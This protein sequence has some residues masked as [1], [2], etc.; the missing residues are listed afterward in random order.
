M[1]DARELIDEK[2]LQVEAERPSDER[3][4]RVAELPAETANGPLAVGADHNGT[5]HLLIPVTSHQVVRRGL[6][7]PVLVLRKRPLEDSRHYQQYAD[8]GCLRVDLNDVFTTLC[9]DVLSTT[10]ALPNN[11]LKALY[12]VIDRWKSLFRTSGAPLDTEQ[13]SG[14]FGELLVLTRLLRRDASAHRLWKGPTGGE[15]DFTSVRSAVEVK[16]SSGAHQRHVRIHGL[17]QLTAPG[18]GTLALAWFRLERGSEGDEDLPGLINRALRLCDD[19]STL[20]ALLS[21]VGYYPSDN[22]HYQDT[23]FAVADEHWYTVD[24]AFPKLTRAQLVDLDIAT[25]VSDVSYTVDLSGE[26]PSPMD[27]E[28]VAAFLADLVREQA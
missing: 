17:D 18:N 4:M 21:S 19:E 12:R 27:D 8:L 14:L 23:R 13:I 28:A 22:A 9:A 26:S 5:R 6:D 24:E 7:G 3:A 16:T 2:W 11:P 25:R 20:L 15:Q 1:K 10:T